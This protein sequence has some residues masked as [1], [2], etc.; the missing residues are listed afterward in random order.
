MIQNALKRVQYTGMQ[1]KKIPQFVF[2]KNKCK[3]F[4]K[5]LK[6]SKTLKKNYTSMIQKEPFLFF[7]NS[8]TIFF[9]LKVQ[10]VPLAKL[11]KML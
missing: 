8:P 4:Q 7:K 5:D 3:K 1:E 9:F 6:C 10:K 11:F 2:E